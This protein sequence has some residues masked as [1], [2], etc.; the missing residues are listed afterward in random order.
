[1]KFS[2]LWVLAAVLLAGGC[3]SSSKTTEKFDKD[4]NVRTEDSRER[5]GTKDDKVII[6][7]KVYLEEELW[8]LNTDVQEMENSIYGRSRRDPGGLWESLKV[9][10]QNLA[11]PRVGG[12]GKPEQMEKWGKVS[13]REDDYEYKIDSRNNLI[14]V[15]EEKLEE[16]ISRYQ[17][18]KRILGDAFERFR[19]EMD[20]CESNYRAALVNHGLNPDD[21]KARGEWVEGSDGVK[22]WKMRRSSSSDPEELMRRKEK[23]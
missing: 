13:E 21:T 11:D 23:K 18:H 2:K 12:T 14:G 10:R 6:Q 17:K 8:K 20:S 1:M 22:V 16:R 5:V 15:S 19:G 9:C 7:K 4:L 3:A